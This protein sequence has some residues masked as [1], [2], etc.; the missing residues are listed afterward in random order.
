MR[1]DLILN[2]RTSFSF[3][4]ILRKR[5]YGKS[6]QPRSAR[7]YFPSEAKLL[8]LLFTHIVYLYEELTLLFTQAK[9]LTLLCTHF[10]YRYEEL[11]I[12]FSLYDGQFQLGCCAHLF[13]LE[14]FIEFVA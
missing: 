12:Q 11:L 5:R 13:K 7:G 1:Q 8:T 2:G 3:Q 9:L 14:R 10:F 4:E 6:P